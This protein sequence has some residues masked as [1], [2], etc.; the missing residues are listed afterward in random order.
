LIEWIRLPRS[1]WCLCKTFDA[2]KKPL[3][4]SMVQRHCHLWLQ[5]IQW[6]DSKAA[7]DS[8]AKPFL[9]PPKW[10]ISWANFQWGYRKRVRDNQTERQGM[11][12]FTNWYKKGLEAQTW[13]L[14]H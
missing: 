5:S 8:E 7:T 4:E 14:I 1:P 13:L 10:G 12:C 6:V 2:P 9:E 3:F 11:G